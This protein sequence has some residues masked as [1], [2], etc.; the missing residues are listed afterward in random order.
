ML[1]AIRVNQHER[2]HSRV[3]LPAGA[4][5]T[6]VIRVS[7]AQVDDVDMINFHGAYSLTRVSVLLS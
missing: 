3:T 2:R 7:M 5:E 6:A 1:R 4:L